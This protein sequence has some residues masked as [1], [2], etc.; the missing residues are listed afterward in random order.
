MYVLQL[1]RKHSHVVLLKMCARKGSKISRAYIKSHTPI[2]HDLGPSQVA[3]LTFC[4]V[5]KV[6]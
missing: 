2:H 5:K 1:V 4:V 3:F 6:D